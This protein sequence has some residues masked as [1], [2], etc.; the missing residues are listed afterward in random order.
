LLGVLAGVRQPISQQLAH[1]RQPRTGLDERLADL[2]VEFLLRVAVAEGLVE[3]R[4]QRW[5][6][7]LL[8]Q[9]GAR[10][11]GFRHQLV[12]GLLGVL[13][14]LIPA[15]LDDRDVEAFQFLDAAGD[16]FLHRFDLGLLVGAAR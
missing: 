14:A 3:R 5:N 7:V 9:L 15:I 6:G 16:A 13:Q 12:H 4:A 10:A 8:V 2:V 1:S 11:H